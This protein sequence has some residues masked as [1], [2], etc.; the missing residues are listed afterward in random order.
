MLKKTR[1]TTT[2]AACESFAIVASKYNRRYVDGMLKAA[3]AELTAAGAAAVKVVRVPGAFEIPAVAAALAASESP[4][5]GAIICLGVI[6]QGET[7]HADH[8]GQAVSHALADIQVFSSKPVIHE[9]LQFTSVEQAKV[10]CLG[11]EHNRGAEA[12]QTAIEMAGVM[13]GLSR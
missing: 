10:R 3:K 1:K 8:I 6:L 13:R 4:S 12:A 11:K 9:V 2:K 7:T 5:Y